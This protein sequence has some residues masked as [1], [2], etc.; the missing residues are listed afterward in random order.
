[1]SVEVSVSPTKK[2]SILGGGL[3]SQ[4]WS[5]SSSLSSS[6]F[7]FIS[8]RKMFPGLI[9][10]CRMLGLT[11]YWWPGKLHYMF[12]SSWV[13]KFSSPVT[14]AQRPLMGSSVLSNS[15]KGWPTGWTMTQWSTGFQVTRE[16]LW[17][18]QWWSCRTLTGTATVKDGNKL[19]RQLAIPVWVTQTA[20]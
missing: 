15:H 1:M 2:P 6:L 10:W 19:P 8:H 5:M 7:P 14:I 20:A 12:V 13:E 3:T 11:K 4:P 16:L 17:K 18:T 9:S